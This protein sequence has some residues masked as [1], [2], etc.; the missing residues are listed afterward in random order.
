MHVSAFLEALTVVL[1]TAGAVSLLFRRLR[2]P[3]VL[4]Y[5]LAG[6]IVGPHLPIP[7]VADREAVETLSEL[8]VILLMFALGLEFSLTRLIAVAPV[9]GLTAVIQS[10]LMIWLGYAIGQAFG[11]TAYES[12]FA[13]AIIAISSTTI[14][15]KA[16][17][18][19]GVGGRL[20]ELVV[21]ILVVEDLIAIVLIAIFTTIGAGGDLSAG[22]LVRTGGQLVAFLAG[23][24]VTGMLL[25]PALMRVVE[26]LR[27]PETTLV[28]ALAICFGTALLAH[29]LGYSVALGAF[30]AG[31]LIAEAGH[32]RSVEHVVQPVRDLFAAVFFVSVG[33]LI[34]P[35]VIAE[36]WP[37]VAV[38][39]AVVIFGKI[40]GVSLGAFLA[41]SGVRTSVRSGMSLAQIGEFSFIIGGIGVSTGATGA[42][43]Y[44]IAVAVSALTTLT[45]PWLIRGSGRAASF[46]DRKLPRPLQ[47]FAALYTSWVEQIRSAPRH[48]AGARARRLAGL[49]LLDAFMFA[50]IVIAAATA[51]RT[52]IA[53]LGQ[54]VG[55]SAGIARVVV[56]VATL[57]LLAPFAVGILRIGRRLGLALA[58]IVLPAAAAGELDLSAAPRR[59]LVVALQMA[60]V[61][62]VALPLAAMA[63]LVMPGVVAVIAM[64]LLMVLLGAGFW[65]GATNLHGHV[66]ASAEVIAEALSARAQRGQGG[67][68]TADAL[69]PIATLLPGL[70]RPVSLRI[71]DDSPALGKTLAELDLRGLTG[72]TVLAIVRAGQD[73]VIPTAADTIRA[74]DQ[75]ALAGTTEAVA[76]ATTILRGPPR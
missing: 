31:S 11:W 45:T 22:T 35:V 28:V 60:T 21:G 46:V 13:G 64:G 26:R 66:R 1:C 55:L 20:R 44:P 18:E 56:T 72:A 71:D 42:F 25:V 10:S 50:S 19:E 5:I 59:A 38:L 3:V 14:I 41:G 37:A 54:H 29:E 76:A 17:D 40:I 51:G 27:S 52:V 32:A 36:H 68:Q 4:G 47:T 74:G 30:L 8:G 6:M 73:V 58:E 15:A 9:A 62:P 75:L 39:T 24:M 12:F 63:Y 70:G 69:A 33:M 48:A 34:D 7:L 2:Q 43:L 16:F 23:L 61:L 49:L 57:V 67:D 65:R 53:F